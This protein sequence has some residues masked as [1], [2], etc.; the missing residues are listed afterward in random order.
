MG[1]TAAVVGKIRSVPKVVLGSGPRFVTARGAS[2]SQ[3]SPT[4][5]SR[6]GRAGNDGGGEGATRHPQDDRA[7]QP[8]THQR[9]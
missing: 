4:P 7:T 8:G 2:L 6:G 3:A 9:R 1:V 5:G